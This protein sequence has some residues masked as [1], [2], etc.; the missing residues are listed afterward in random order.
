MDLVLSTHSVAIGV[1]VEN[2]CRYYDGAALCAIWSKPSKNAIR[3][4]LKAFI[5]EDCEVWDDAYLFA[6]LADVCLQVLVRGHAAYVHFGV[7]VRLLASHNEYAAIQQVLAVSGYSNSSSADPSPAKDASPNAFPS[8]S[9][10]SS[11]PSLPTHPDPSGFC[12][13][14][15]ALTSF[16]PFGCDPSPFPSP[17]FQY[18]PP[19]PLILPESCASTPGPGPLT[20]S[21]PLASPTSSSPS[22]SFF[23]PIT[24]TNPSMDVSDHDVQL[25]ASYASSP[26]LSLLTAK[27]IPLNP[28]PT[29]GL[30][31]YQLF[32]ADVADCRMS[33]ARM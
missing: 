21:P 22:S 31:S 6:A 30:S 15:P 23:S 14:T 1:L 7:V 20:M 8:P 26:S 28:H 19:S 25:D 2:Q 17:S 16:A 33:R 11:V 5:Q 18:V 24:N 12:T 4:R 9:S 3:K 13:A 27:E 32:L 10:P 29:V